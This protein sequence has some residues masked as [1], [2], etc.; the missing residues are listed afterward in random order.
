LDSWKDMDR[1]SFEISCL[2]ITYDNLSKEIKAIIT[3]PQYAAYRNPHWSKWDI[4]E[5][6][7]IAD[8]KRKEEARWWEEQR[9][10]TPSRSTQPCHSCKGPWELDHRCRGKD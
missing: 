4:L 7:I 2:E 8:K 3:F 10:P 9:N 6:I 1:I 5:G